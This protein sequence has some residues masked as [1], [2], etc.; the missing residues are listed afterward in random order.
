MKYFAGIGSRKTPIDVLRHVEQ[1]SKAFTE[2]GYILRSGGAKGADSHFEKTALNKEIYYANDATKE[3]IELASQYHPAWHNCNDY[4]RK[5]H[6]RNSMIILGHDLN[7]P[8]DFVICWT[9]DG[10]ATGGTGLGIN[11]ANDKDIPVYNLAL[12]NDI[13]VLRWVYLQQRKRND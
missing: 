10:K 6:G 8:V 3:A 2:L 9:P 4:A 5:L 13:E 1:I 12:K 7:T 11:L